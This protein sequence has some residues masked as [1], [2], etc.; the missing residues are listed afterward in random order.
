MQ[1][2]QITISILLTFAFVYIINA[3]EKALSSDSDTTFWFQNSTQLTNEIGL[4]S[5]Q[6]SREKYEVRFWD[7]NKVIR[8]WGCS[9]SLHGEVIYFLRQYHKHDN[10]S[11]YRL[12]ELYYRKERLRQETVESIE[13]LISDFEI[14]LIPSMDQIEGWNSNAV[15]GRLYI[16]EASSLEKYSFKSYKYVHPYPQE[17]RTISYFFQYINSLEQI[18]NGL[19]DFISDQPFRIYY[20]GI[21]SGTLQFSSSFIEWYWTKPRR[22]FRRIFPPNIDRIRS[23]LRKNNQYKLESKSA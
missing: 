1:L 4:V 14:S 20:N 9:E 13:Y 8:L 16:I 18:R 7:D 15:H 22:L 3:Q 19:Y 11:K 17:A 2:T 23:K 12:G 10:Y 5:I 6:K 21:N